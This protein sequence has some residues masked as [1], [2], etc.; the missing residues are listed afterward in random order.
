MAWVDA[1]Y[2][3]VFIDVG[4][5]GAMSD[6]II[7]KESKKWDKCWKINTLNIPE[8]RRLPGDENGRVM[9]FFV[10]ADEAFDLSKNILSPYAKKKKKEFV[11]PYKNIHNYRY[12]RAR[13]MVECT[14]GILANKWRILHGPIDVNEYFCD[15]IL[16]CCCILHNFIRAKDGV[17]FDDTVSA[18][19][20]DDA[21]F[22]PSPNR[23]TDVRQY[24][25]SYF[26]SAAG[27]LPWQY[28]KI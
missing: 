3:F 5:L 4:S 10:V 23:G 27:S 28:N 12:T 1:Q 26:T 18:S 25:S 17:R 14:F 9:P 6:S 19:P 15:K 20:L 7:F 21:S 24:L 2:N 11:N 16:M 13:R 22:E 8:G